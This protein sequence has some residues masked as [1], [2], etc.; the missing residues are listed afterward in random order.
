[1]LLIA[2]LGHRRT[3]GTAPPTPGRYYAV[4]AAAWLF[5]G[6]WLVGLYWTTSGGLGPSRWLAWILLTITTPDL[7]SLFWSPSRYLAELERQARPPAKRWF[8]D[9]KSGDKQ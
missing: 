7:P 1:M 3:S 9:V 2:R 5:T 6:A 8:T 4:L